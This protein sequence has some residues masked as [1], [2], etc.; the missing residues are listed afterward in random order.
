MF[1]VA[2]ELRDAPHLRGK[3]VAVGGYSMLTTT[4]YEARKF[5]VRSA[6]PGFIG[7]VLCEFLDDGRFVYLCRVQK[8]CPELIMLP[9]NFDKYRAVSAQIRAI[10]EEYD[11][12]FLPMSLDEVIAISVLTNECLC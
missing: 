5:G 8:L 9:V 1:Y 4:S 7:K 3:P 10:F 6:M 11:P 2:V 12:R